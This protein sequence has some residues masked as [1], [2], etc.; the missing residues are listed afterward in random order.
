MHTPQ[1]QLSPLKF[2]VSILK[3]HL[4]ASKWYN[5]NVTYV[6]MKIYAM[7]SG[8]SLQTRELDFLNISIYH[9]LHIC[10]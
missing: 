8:T 10:R 9:G 5:K 3:I 1:S 4:R 2:R 6:V 7:C